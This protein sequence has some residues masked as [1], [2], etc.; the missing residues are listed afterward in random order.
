MKNFLT[1]LTLNLIDKDIIKTAYYLDDPHQK[2]WFVT[3][4]SN[5]KSKIMQKLGVLYTGSFTG[6]GFSFISR[7]QAL[8]NAAEDIYGKILSHS[9]FSNKTQV[10]DYTYN[11]KVYKNIGQVRAEDVIKKTVLQVPTQ[12][13]FGNYRS[14]HIFEYNQDEPEVWNFNSFGSGFGSSKKKAVIEALY[15]LIEI[16]SVINAVSLDKA[17]TS[18]IDTTILSL[19]VAKMVNVN[20]QK[21]NYWYLYDVTS[22]LGIPT[23]IS[24]LID[25]SGKGPAFSIG[26][27]SNLNSKSAIEKSVEKAYAY[28]FFTQRL[29]LQFGKTVIKES[30]LDTPLNRLLFWSQIESLKYVESLFRLPIKKPRFYS[31]LQ[32]FTLQKR[33]D[34]I[35]ERLKRF[36]IDAYVVWLKNPLA[37][38]NNLYCCRVVT[39]HMHAILNY[40]SILYNVGSQYRYAEYKKLIFRPLTRPPFVYL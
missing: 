34:F 26:Y 12:C 6:C 27:G 7:Q 40:Y 36:H 9:L 29:K 38:I 31:H 18:M 2:E 5:T 24:L 16:D 3:L 15:S 25:K 32:K 21:H 20:L 19:S 11:N 33:L 28:R 22:D 14:F 30:D 23:Y 13:V 10:A 35:R 37:T 39:Q 1:A 17:I 4:A 8:E